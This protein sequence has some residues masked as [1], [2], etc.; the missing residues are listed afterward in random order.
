[1]CVHPFN[2]TYVF[3]WVDVL[4]RLYSLGHMYPCLCPILALC[5]RSGTTS[6]YI[7]LVRA[8][9]HYSPPLVYLKLGCQSPVHNLHLPQHCRV[10][11]L[12][13]RTLLGSGIA[14]FGCAV[15]L[16]GVTTRSSLLRTP[17]F[18]STIRS[19]YFFP[20]RPLTRSRK[21]SESVPSPRNPTGLFRDP[22]LSTSWQTKLR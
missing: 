6:V 13:F 22:T 9:N 12:Q 5:L 21:C 14:I 16:F 2:H 7:H 4:P 10:H 17:A 20:V 8:S 3:P 19:R 1:M 18:H 11:T 15:G